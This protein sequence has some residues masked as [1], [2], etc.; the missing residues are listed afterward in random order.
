MAESKDISAAERYTKALEE[1]GGD[2]AIKRYASLS[3]DLER[4]VN[5]NHE[6]AKRE[7]I[8]LVTQSLE[9]QLLDIDQLYNEATQIEEC[10]QDFAK[11]ISRMTKG[12]YHPAKIKSKDR[13]LFKTRK[14]FFN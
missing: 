13:A 11:E 3:R 6:M 10:I 5:K 14:L 9:Y 1:A 4:M 7:G 8:P 2:V 12:T